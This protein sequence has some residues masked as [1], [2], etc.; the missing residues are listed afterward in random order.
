[1]RDR[2]ELNIAVSLVLLDAVEEALLKGLTDLLG[3][4]SSVGVLS[5][6]KAMTS[7]QH[8]ADSVKELA[9]ATSMYNHWFKNALATT[10]VG[11]VR[12]STKLIS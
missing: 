6:P 11:M 4:P 9:G 12:S 7:L 2:F 1:M 5:S 10:A 3:L 8:G